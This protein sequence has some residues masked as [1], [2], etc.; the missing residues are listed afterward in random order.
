MTIQLTSD[1]GGDVEI[2]LERPLGVNENPVGVATYGKLYTKAAGGVT[3]LWFVSGAGIAYQLTPTAAPGDTPWLR[4]LTDVRLDQAGDTEVTPFDDGA[5]TLG[6]NTTPALS[7]RWL[8]VITTSNGLS[9]FALPGDAERDS[10]FGGSGLGWGPGGATA[11]DAGMQRTAA[12][13][14]A[15]SNPDSGAS[16]GL[17]P[18]AD[19]DAT[20]IL[21]DTANRWRAVS[22]S[23]SYRVYGNGIANTTAQ[24]GGAGGNRLDLGDGVTPANNAGLRWFSQNTIS[25]NDGGA[26]SGN[27]VPEVDATGTIGQNT[28]RW[29]SH[30]TVGGATVATGFRAWDG[31]AVPTA[32]LSGDSAGGGYLKLGDN[33][34]T[35]VRLQRTAATQL[36][37]S[38]AAGAVGIDVVPPATFGA[39]PPGTGRL[40]TAANKWAELNAFTVITGDV[41]FTDPGCPVCG[42]EFAE[43][44][45]LV[46]RVIKTSR[47]A[48]GGPLTRTVPCHHGCK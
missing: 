14:I 46:M 17:F 20:A 42:Q 34:T 45:D 12:S 5:T 9:T 32:Q 18:I 40:G 37:I 21:G 13:R 22:V 41:V 33:A 29:E 30:N 6:L 44:D 36:M 7:R 19:G 35:D 28:Q 3:Q 16:G 39:P 24:L 47:A 48:D 8:G 4:T 43:G 26:A 11:P 10:F 1:I 2:I 38:D 15:V 27:V 23:A 25:I 31:G